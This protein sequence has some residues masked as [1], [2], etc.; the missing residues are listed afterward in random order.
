MLVAESNLSHAKRLSEMICII[1]RGEIVFKGRAA[2]LSEKKDLEKL[3][4][5]Y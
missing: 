5:G 1:E 2:D 4:R 3:V